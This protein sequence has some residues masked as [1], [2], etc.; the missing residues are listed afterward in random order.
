MHLFVLKGRRRIIF[1]RKGLRLRMEIMLRP[2]LL[3]LA[4]LAAVASAV[5][6]SGGQE[7]LAPNDAPGIDETNSVLM[8]VAAQLQSKVRLPTQSM[9]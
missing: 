1:A 3:P 6:T 9:T 5:P 4:L 2:A 7:Q 8:A